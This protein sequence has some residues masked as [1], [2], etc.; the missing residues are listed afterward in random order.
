MARKLS[1]HFIPNL[2]AKVRTENLKKACRKLSKLVVLTQEE[3]TSWKDT[4]NIEV[5][6]NALSYYPEIIANGDAKSAIA[7]GRLVY[8]KGFDLLI[9]AWADIYEKHPDWE[10]HIYC[11]G[12]EKDNLFRLIQK[13][14]LDSVIKI[15]EPVKDIYKQYIKHSMFLFP[16]RYLEALP[17][18]LVEAMSCGLPLV[19]FDSPCGPKDV[20]ADGE[21]GFL[22]KYG[23]LKT[24]SEKINNLIDSEQ[25]RKSMRARAHEMSLNYNEE[26]IMK[27]WIK[28]FSDI[29]K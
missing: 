25:L 3:K 13:K 18:V 29:K 28:L 11:E 23:E 24:F 2:V 16:S 1:K 22:I 12:N 21:N 17:M 5:I 7:V 20:I 15:H 27:Q 4:N 19:A 10:L 6:P 9:E 8:E 14:Q 26:I